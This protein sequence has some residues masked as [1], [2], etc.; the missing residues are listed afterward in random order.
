MKKMACVGCGMPMDA[1]IGVCPH[2][3]RPNDENEIELA[4]T[5]A[6]RGRL[7]ERNRYKRIAAWGVVAVLTTGLILGHKELMSVYG[8]WRAQFDKALDH[9]ADG[10]DAAP[11]AQIGVSASS[12][13]AQSAP[14]AEAVKVSTVIAYSPPVDPPIGEEQWG[15]AGRAIDLKTLKPIWGARLTF[16]VASGGGGFDAYTDKLGEFRVVLPKGVPDGFTVH[17]STPGYAPVAMCERDIPYLTLSASDRAQ[18]IGIA[19]E[20][21]GP[22]S[23]I[24]EPEAG[25]S[26][27]VRQDLFF[28][29]RE[30]Q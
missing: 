8:V 28:A 4:S 5:Q 19:L 18:L 10:G 23:H 26:V 9:A 24:P 2:C 11:A 21:D 25:A 16:Q 13:T 14:G 29:P 17:Y 3:R 7:E 12:G 15:V 22:Q 1:V 27:R 20:G 30:R 6:Q